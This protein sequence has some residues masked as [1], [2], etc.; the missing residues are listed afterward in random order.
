M[1]TRN[2]EDSN[3][4]TTQEAGKDSLNSFPMEHNATGNFDKLLE[5]IGAPQSTP[6]RH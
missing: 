1:T 3:D 4:P 5:Q 2:P 6:N